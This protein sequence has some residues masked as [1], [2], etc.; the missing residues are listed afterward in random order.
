MVEVELPGGEAIEVEVSG[1]GPVVMLLVD[2][3]P[4]TGERADEMRQ[5]GVDPQLGLTLI[6]GLRDRYLVVAVPYEAHLLANPRPETLTPEAVAA[7]LLAIADAVDADRFACYGYSWL[8]VAALQ[9]A[10]RTDRLAAL[11]MGGYP[12]LAG[13][14]REMLAVTTATHEMATGARPR[15]V[16]EP[17]TEWDST[18]MTLSPAQTGQFVTFYVALEGFDDRA[19]LARVTCPRL[20]FVGAEDRIEYGGRWGGV[21]VDIAGPVRV[22]EAALRA[23]GWTVHLLD[24]L[25]HIQAM[26]P[27]HVLPVL[28]PWL[29]EVLLDG[30][31]SD[32]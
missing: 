16:A 28:R 21:V 31:P 1:A 23:A 30:G 26:Q 6:E 14:Y 32:G 25:D 18:E 29:D 24:G 10:L 22:G 27:N 15:A 19:A 13:P 2:P 17:E 11:A 12:P 3:R 20:C 8:A 7:D 9:L 5:W 4:A